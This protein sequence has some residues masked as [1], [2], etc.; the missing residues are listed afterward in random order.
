MLGSTVIKDGAVVRALT[1]HQ[2]SLGFIPG[3]TCGMSLLLVL[4]LA[5]KGFSLD[6]SSSLPSNQHIQI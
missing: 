5:P 1:S 4:S 6:T 2:F 3:V